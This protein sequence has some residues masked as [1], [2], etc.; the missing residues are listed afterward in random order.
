[1]KII[2]FNVKPCI[3]EKLMPLTELANNLWTTWNYEATNL[4]LRLDYDSWIASNQNPVKML[5]LVSQKKLEQMAMDDSYLAALETVYGKFTR[6][7]TGERWYKDSH[8]NVIAYFSMEYGLDISLPIYSGGLGVLSGDHL[9]TCSDLGLPVVGI[10]LLYRQGYFHQYFNRDGFQQESYP[11]NDWYTMPVTRRTDE[12]GNP[13]VIKITLG[14]SAV[15]AQ[16]WEVK[17]GRNSLYLLDTNIPENNPEDRNITATLYGGGR[18]TRIKQEILLGIGGIRAL[19]ALGINPAVTHMNEGHSA[20][21]ALER[22]RELIEQH[23]LTFDEARQLV[24]VTNVFTTHTP[25]P[26]GNERFPMELMEKYFKNYIKG[27][28]ITWDEFIS[29]GLENPFDSHEQ[30]CLTI[31]ALKLSAYNNGVSR[32]HGRVSRKMWCSIW[33]EL[34]D[35][36]IPIS[37]ITNGVHPKTWLAPAMS[38][39]LDKYFG[40]RFIDEPTNLDIWDRIERISDEELWRT[41]EIRREELVVYARERLKNQF[42]RQGKPDSEIAVAEDVLSPYYLTISFAR[43]F[44]TY[45]RGNLLLKDPDRLIQLLSNKE[46]PIQL[47]FAGKAHP[48]DMPGKEMIKE[49]IHFA[50]DPQVRSK[51]IFLENYDLSLAHYLI[52]GSDIWLNTPRRPLEASGTS[53]MKAAINGVLN[54]SVLDGWWDE[55][56]NPDIGWAIGKGEEYENHDLHDEIES[57]ALYDLLEREIIPLFYSRGRDNLPHAWIKRMKASIKQ[58]GHRFCSPRMLVE[59]SES[60]YFPALSNYLKYTENDYKNAKELSKYLSSLFKY[61]KNIKIKT[62]HTQFDKILTVGEKF[63]VNAKI[64]LGELKPEDVKAEIYYGHLSST[65]IIE[66]AQKLEMNCTGFSNQVGEYSVEVPCTF[67]GRLGFSLRVIPNHPLLVHP[68]IPG[69]VIWS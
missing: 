33:E 69:Q 23:K 38:N 48:D 47:I 4:F 66:E 50:S 8:S 13:I 18:E 55:A 11:E 37:H 16:I 5:G 45:K 22:I 19:R 25:V 60:F 24:W 51:I 30:F 54:V 12:K 68:F 53:G 28:N 42:I 43:R 34:P 56:Y 7:M 49:I 9:K 65:G 32:L 41:H 36:E 6:Y 57:K 26:A 15:T 67:P 20:F 52:S 62:V 14:S 21:L 39:L 35:E 40:P 17:I 59:Y 2:P 44:A 58:I 31:L 1:M 46:H 3:P 29:L 63:T 27:L 61:W 10:G 64:T